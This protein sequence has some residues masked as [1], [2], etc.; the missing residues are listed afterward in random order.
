[1]KKTLLVTILVLTLVACNQKE[2]VDKKVTQ[3]VNQ[4]EISENSQIN[5]ENQNQKDEESEENQ[6]IKRT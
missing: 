2:T 6:E 1:M 3:N 4:E 5:E